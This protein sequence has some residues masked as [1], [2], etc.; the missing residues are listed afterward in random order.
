MLALGVLSTATG[1]AYFAYRWFRIRRFSV[2]IAAEPIRN[3]RLCIVG[4]RLRRES[5]PTVSEL[6]AWCRL[7]ILNIGPEP[8]LLTSIVVQE[9]GRSRQDLIGP[10]V[11]DLHLAYDR[12]SPAE[13]VDLPLTIEPH[14]GMRLWALLP[15]F[16]PDQLGEILFHLYGE[17]ARAFPSFRHLSGRFAEAEA[18]VLDGVREA[19]PII[20]EAALPIKDVACTLHE[21]KL[22]YPVLEKRSGKLEFMPKLGS[23]PLHLLHRVVAAA[24]ERGWTLDQ[25]RSV[26]SRYYRIE[27]RVP[28]GATVTRRLK[29]NGNALWWSEVFSGKRADA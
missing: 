24:K 25:V 27:V 14:H 16:V 28:A 23:V 15:I 8:R 11:K 9:D 19:L 2:R 26:P 18:H 12:D 29:I 4:L 3:E 22:K 10:P 7:S 6:G 5:P 13:P 21:I 1:A 20:R 17:E